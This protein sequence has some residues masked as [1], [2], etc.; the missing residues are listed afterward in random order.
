MAITGLS[1]E[2]FWAQLQGPV[3]EARTRTSTTPYG[4]MAG[5]QNTGISGGLD[6]AAPVGSLGTTP[7][8]NPTMFSGGS[9]TPN[10]QWD[11]GSFA[12]KFGSPGTPE[13]LVALEPQLQ[14]AG[15]KVLRNAA[16]VAGKIQLPNGQ[17]VDIINSAGAGGKGFQ[18]LTGGG[19]A[20]GGG[21]AM[22]DLGY[23]FGSSMAPWTTPFQA[24]DPN[25]IA[26]DPAY[27]FQ[28]KEGLN[29]VQNSAAAR[30]TLKTGGT[31]KGLE[32]YAQ[33]LASTYNDKYYGRD[34]GEYLLG[35]ENFWQ[36]QDRPFNKNLSLAELGRPQ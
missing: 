19:P 31:L 4:T 30:G 20:G 7:M 11:Q 12:A 24:R 28:L 26:N 1:P 34:M 16:G 8:Q 10:Q 18:W 36:N 29:A 25:Q 33:G 17:I 15:I 9:V 5:S 2:D 3:D 23:G 27:Q 6:T 21:S 14:Q 13:E 22:A 32:Q 35:R